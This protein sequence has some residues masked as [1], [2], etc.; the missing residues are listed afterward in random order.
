M[1]NWKELEKFIAPG[2]VV[3]LVIIIDGKEIGALSFNVDTLAYKAILESV[4]NIET[5]VERISIPDKPEKKE[6]PAS[7]GKGKTKG[8]PIK[9]EKI[10]P[11]VMDDDLEEEEEL[12]DENTE[13]IN[14]VEP[15]ADAD[16]IKR[17]AIGHPSNDTTKPMTREQ[18]MAED[19]KE[20]IKD[21]FPK[22][23][24]GFIDNHIVVGT[25]DNAEAK[26]NEHSGSKSA[27]ND[28]QPDSANKPVQQQSFGEEW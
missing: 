12:E 24:K 23:E 4:S 18:I 13:D 26:A 10:E 9:E 20:E 16:M 27:E 28:G 25:I 6:Q 22:A 21:K 11:E 17:N 7:T 14:S 8:K 19:L 1:I 5:K 2:K 3:T 15:P